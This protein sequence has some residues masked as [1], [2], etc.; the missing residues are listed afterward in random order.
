MLDDHSFA[1]LGEDGALASAKFHLGV[2]AAHASDR[3]IYNP[4]N[5]FLFYDHDGKGG[6]DEIH[7]ATLAPHLALHNSDFLV[8]LI[9]I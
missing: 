5:G 1:G 2:A 3:I 9:A 4:D 8:E 6:A 7:F